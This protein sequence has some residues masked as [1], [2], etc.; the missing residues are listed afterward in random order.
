[1]NELEDEVILLKKIGESSKIISDFLKNSQNQGYATNF[2]QGTLEL[3]I[4]MLDAMV[5]ASDKVLE[6][7][8]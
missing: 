4:A 2:D 1:M 5:N 8:K 7:E 6:G 3:F